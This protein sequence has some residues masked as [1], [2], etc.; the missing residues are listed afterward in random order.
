MN[1]T[2]IDNWILAITKQRYSLRA[3]KDIITAYVEGMNSAYS[4]SDIKDIINRSIELTIKRLA[5]GNELDTLN[6]M[7]WV[8]SAS[9]ATISR[10]IERFRKEF[11][12]FKNKLGEDGFFNLLCRV[13]KNCLMKQLDGD[14]VCAG[15]ASR[16]G[17]SICDPK[18]PS[19]D[20]ILDLVK[21][22]VIRIVLSDKNNYRDVTI[23][24]VLRSV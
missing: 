4:E 3:L 24:N 8:E 12:D 19:I 16:L 17:R 23:E 6:K 15:L 1:I 14:E 21:N 9:A 18:Y 10:L 5:R 20:N 13:H 7:Y 2:N 11:D 22:D